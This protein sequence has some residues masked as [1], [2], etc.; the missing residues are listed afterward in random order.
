ML[1]HVYYSC[2]TRENETWFY[3]ILF[4]FY[5]VVVLLNEVSGRTNCYRQF[6]DHLR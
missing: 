5:G 1:C 3:V 6:T 2:Y 4:Y